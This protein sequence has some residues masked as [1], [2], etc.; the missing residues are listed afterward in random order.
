MSTITLTYYTYA[1]GHPECVLIYSEPLSQQLLER[2]DGYIEGLAGIDS[3]LK[4]GNEADKAAKIASVEADLLQISHDMNLAITFRVTHEH[5][6][7]QREDL[8]PPPYC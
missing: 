4:G 7:T 8:G 5:V 6:E 1:C 3:L 2:L